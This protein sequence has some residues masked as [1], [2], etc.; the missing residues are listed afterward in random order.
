MNRLTNL[1]SKQIKI[2]IEKA[3]NESIE[4]IDRVDIVSK[5][6]YYDEINLVFFIENFKMPC[7]LILT[8]EETILGDYLLDYLMLENNVYYFTNRIENELQ[9]IMI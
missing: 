7:E 9:K 1:D 5:D 6:E 3:L 4:L 2:I 8:I